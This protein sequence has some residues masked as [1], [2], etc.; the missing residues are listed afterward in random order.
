MIDHTATLP[1]GVR[2]RVSASVRKTIGVE[3][4]RLGRNVAFRLIVSLLLASYTMLSAGNVNAAEPMF[5]PHLLAV[6]AALSGLLAAD[7][8]VRAPQLIGGIIAWRTPFTVSSEPTKKQKWASVVFSV[9]VWILP[10][11]AATHSVLSG[12]A[13]AIALLPLIAF[14]TNVILRTT[15]A[16]WSGL[17]ARVTLDLIEGRDP[18]DS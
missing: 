5:F 8:T 16:Q 2:D 12:I 15:L 6:V 10:L 14:V 3:N 18:D 1:T 9:A 11:I 7:L 4:T 17:P 13:L